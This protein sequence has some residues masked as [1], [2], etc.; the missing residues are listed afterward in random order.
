MISVALRE[1]DV[2][3]GEIVVMPN[4]GTISLNFTFSYK[5]HDGYAYEALSS[6][7]EYLLST[8][9][10]G[11]LSVLLKENIPS[12]SLLKKLGYAIWVIC[13]QRILKYLV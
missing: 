6:L 12:M 3:I 8:I 11:I 7:I 2:M 1:T 5:V 10:S 4:D 13:R 9:L